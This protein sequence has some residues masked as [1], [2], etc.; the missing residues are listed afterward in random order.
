[1]S[2]NAGKLTGN[3]S[4]NP[5]GKIHA[6]LT[7]QT[8]IVILVSVNRLSTLTTGYVLPNEFLRWVDLHNM[9]TLP[10]ALVAVWYLLKRQV[11]T[12]SKHA[13]QNKS[14]H[15]LLNL[16]FILGVYLL[17]TGYGSHEVTNYLH[18]RFC[19]DSGNDALCRIIIYNDD[20]FSHVVWFTGF[21]L[22]NVALM[23]MQ[24]L[25][26]YPSLLTVRDQGLL[27]LNSLFVGA[28]VFANLAFEPIG[29]DLYVIALLAILALALVW[30]YDR[31]PLLVFFSVA[32]SLGLV[33]TFIYKMTA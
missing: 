24:V 11:E 27:A 21:I 18:V 32:Y 26:P 31:Q 15:L 5:I 29:L 3:S 9:L 22:P 2:S 10:V 30:K 4:S 19:T 14:A 16:T 1:M 12:S 33:A 8:I 28:S 25:F 13:A 17:G 7:V 23:F 20:T 6:L